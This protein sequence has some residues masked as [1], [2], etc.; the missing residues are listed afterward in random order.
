[1]AQAL[2]SSKTLRRYGFFA[3][4]GFMLSHPLIAGL[5]LLIVALNYI[6]A[7]I[8]TRLVSTRAS[9]FFLSLWHEPAIS[10]FWSHILYG[11]WWVGLWSAKIAA[12]LLGFYIAF[13][14]IYILV[15]PLY[16]WLS[17]ICEKAAKQM[18]TE[19]VFSMKQLWFDLKEAIKISLFGILLSIIALFFL[20]IPV[21]GT[22]AGFLLYLYS[23]SIL[24]LDYIASRKGMTLA[25]KVR[26]ASK[27]PWFII[28]LG[29]APALLSYIPVVS[30]FLVSMVFPFFVVY[31]TLNFLAFEDNNPAGRMPLL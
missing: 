16:S 17:H 21:I 27:H 28:S 15:S 10:G 26:W 14:A 5:S 19:T 18:V 20:F 24:F 7:Y 12:V 6:G 9:M 13:L 4:L 25:Q 30:I 8:L 31:A 22:V 23:Y 11:L 1:M 29:W 2:S 3:T